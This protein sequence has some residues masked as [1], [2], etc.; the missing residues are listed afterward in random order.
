MNRFLTQAENL[1]SNRQSLTEPVSHK[2]EKKGLFYCEFLTKKRGKE[3]S[4]IVP[5]LLLLLSLV[6]FLFPFLT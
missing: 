6:F 5:L 4:V 1:A 3:G 2:A